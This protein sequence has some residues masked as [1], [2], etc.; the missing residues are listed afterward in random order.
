MAGG[1]NGSEIQQQYG[2]AA[3][4]SLTEQ[5]ELGATEMD[6]SLDA[7]MRVLMRRDPNFAVQFAKYYRNSN[8]ASFA[9]STNNTTA[10]SA[11]SHA[12]NT[13]SNAAARPYSQSSS[14][15][16]VESLLPH[17]HKAK[18]KVSQFTAVATQ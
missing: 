1:A 6:E 7:C 8:S 5:A 18:L 16:S 12:S 9:C 17:S 14:G 11:T 3:V 10:A 15:L 13:N 4:D 2:G